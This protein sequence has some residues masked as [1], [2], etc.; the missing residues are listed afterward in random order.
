MGLIDVDMRQVLQRS[1][2]VLSQRTLAA[3]V[4]DRTFGAKRGG[5]ARNRIR[6][7]R[8]GGRDHAAEL[9]GLACIAV[10]GMRGNLLM[11]D[12]DDANPFIDAAIVDVDDVAAAKRE[13]RVDALVLQRL[14]DQMAARD[15]A[16]SRLLRCRV[17]SAV[18]LALG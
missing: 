1:H 12:V 5:N 10:G 16:A 15:H 8:P 7:A 18:V 11:A 3:D 6:E 2:L 17:S 4:Q 14:G 9:A 13:Y